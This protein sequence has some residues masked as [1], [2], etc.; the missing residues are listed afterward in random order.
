MWAWRMVFFCE[1]QASS[2]LIMH[3]V[4]VMLCTG[5]LRHH[6]LEQHCLVNIDACKTYARNIYF[7]L[8]Y[9]STIAHLQ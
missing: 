4:I 9:F 1:T 7:I 2:N 8:F 5:L 3:D 6:W